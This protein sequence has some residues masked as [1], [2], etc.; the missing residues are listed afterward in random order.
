MKLFS[1]LMLAAFVAATA[2]CGPS[3]LAA[4]PPRSAASDG[5]PSPARPPTVA[6][7]D[8]PSIDANGAPSARVPASAQG[9]RGRIM[10]KTGNFMPRT[11]ERGAPPSGAIKKAGAPPSTPTTTPLSVPVHVFRGGDIPSTTSFD[12]KHPAFLT[13]VNSDASGSYV[14]AL[15]PGKYTIVAEIDGKLYLNSYAGDDAW[16]S[17][18]VAANSW[19]E[20]DIHDTSGATF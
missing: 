8:T 19:T 16:S 18:D 7:I 11:V 10:K 3:E 4:V 5:P 17:I 14:V 15:A 13:T 1:L 12:P 2:S 20:W 9:V 6:P